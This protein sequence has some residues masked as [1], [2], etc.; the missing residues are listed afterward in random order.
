MA[1]MV[2]RGSPTALGRADPSTSSK[3]LQ[4]PLRERAR[5]GHSRA[6]MAP[7]GYSSGGASVHRQSIASN[8]GSGVAKIGK[9]AMQAV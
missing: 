2:T 3:I 8:D 9:A 4:G 1:P 6:G 7:P 5:S